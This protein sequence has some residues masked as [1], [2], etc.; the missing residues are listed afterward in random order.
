[1]V[2]IWSHIKS[3]N[4]VIS[5][6]ASLM[7]AL[8][9]DDLASWWWKWSFSKLNIPHSWLY[10]DILG[11]IKEGFTMFSVINVWLTNM[12]HWLAG[13]YGL[14]TCSSKIKW[15]LNV[16]MFLS[17]NLSRWYPGAAIWYSILF[18]LVS[19]IISSE[20]L[21][22]RRCNIGFVPSLVMSIKQSL[23]TCIRNFFVLFLIGAASM[24]IESKLYI[25]KIYAF[26]IAEV[27]G[28]RPESYV[29]IMPFI[30]SNFISFN[31][32]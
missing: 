30:S 1:M 32:I 4:S 20:T 23:Y 18:F 7:W 27:M 10:A 6:C 5:P 3:R 24:L 28:K 31:P 29:Y 25:T 19:S 16:W 12:Y 14:H 22:S 17:E 21:L 15:F 26:P 8:M 2:H 9:Y 11:L 13:Y